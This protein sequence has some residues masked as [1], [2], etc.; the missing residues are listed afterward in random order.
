MTEGERNLI[1]LALHGSLLSD[2]LPPD[3][4]TIHYSSYLEVSL[5]G[6]QAFTVSDFD[7]EH[8]KLTFK[9]QAW[10]SNLPPY[11]AHDLAQIF[12]QGFCLSLAGH[13]GELALCV[14]A[15]PP[16]LE[17]TKPLEIKTTLTHVAR[18]GYS[19]L[20]RKDSLAR[21]LSQP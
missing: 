16:T 17:S 13:E 7:N 15:P 20:V 3:G 1:S 18:E 5:F 14:C 10:L 11:E 9:G 6:K 4:V 8:L 19:V 21:L 2:V 12:A